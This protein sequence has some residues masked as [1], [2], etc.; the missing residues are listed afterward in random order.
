MAKL[1]KGKIEKEQGEYYYT[2][3]YGRKWS[4]DCLDELFIAIVKRK[5]TENTLDYYS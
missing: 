4:I 3:P 5:E 1:K 2:D